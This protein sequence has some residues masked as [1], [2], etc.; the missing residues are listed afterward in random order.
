M[1]D[2]RKFSKTDSNKRTVFFDDLESLNKFSK[3]NIQSLTD[4]E[5]EE[6][7]KEYPHLLLRDVS[8]NLFLDFANVHLRYL[9]MMESDLGSQ[10]IKSDLVRVQSSLLEKISELRHSLE[11]QESSQLLSFKGTVKLTF[12]SDSKKYVAVYIPEEFDPQSKIDIEMECRIIA[13]KY[14]EVIAYLCQELPTDR[15]KV[16]E[17]CCTPFFQA[18][19]REKLY[20]SAL[21]SKAVAQAQYIERKTKGGD[22]NKK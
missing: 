1:A 21:C 7:I 11:K 20:C 14:F 18:T 4:Q 10:K 19:A 2:T 9:E 8:S 6:F 5:L 17:K 15:L 22:H 3:V 13:V 12:D 16:C